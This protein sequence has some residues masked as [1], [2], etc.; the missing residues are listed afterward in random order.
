[1]RFFLIPC[2]AAAQTTS[3]QFDQMG[4][5][6]F[7]RGLYDKA[8]GYYQQA[9][10]ADPNNAQAFEDLGNAYMKK[11]D[12][13]DAVA[14]YQKSLQI[15][16]NN[17]TLKVMVDNMN[18]TPTTA[19]PDNTTNSQA[20]APSNNTVIVQEPA[21]AVVVER[22]RH[23]N[24]PQ[25]LNPDLA[26]IDQAKFWIKAELGY[27]WAQQGDLIN[28]SNTINNGQLN[29]ANATYPN[30]ATGYAG[31]ALASNSGLG[32][33]GEIG[34]LLS[35]HFGL[36]IGSRY[37]QSNDYTADVQYNNSPYNDQENLTLTPAVVP[38][39]L[40][41]YFFLPDHDGR[42]FISAGAGYY[43]GVVHVDQTTTTNNFFGTPT[44][45]TGNSTDEWT[46]DMYSGNIGFQLGIG[47]EFEVSPRFGIEIYGRAY[48]A[49]I[50]NF[51]GTL[52]DGNTSGTFAL[53]SSS[54]GPALVDADNPI[55]VNSANQERYT[56]I[57]FTGFDVGASLNFY[58]F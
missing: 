44:N 51:Q 5:S 32:W 54:S 17:P 47:R 25:N 27:D 30:S 45:G 6:L 2:L 41:L 9:I 52:Y 55:Y 35:P 19:I 15:N 12:Q 37:I 42:F 20:Q 23:R 36:A 11:G 8:I 34:F 48:Y 16:P 1:M 13:P 26:P 14:A 58:Y 3:V 4:Q 18:N 49:Q 57:D 50:T 33:G 43:L 40:D 22:V 39:T 29:Y 53:A 46:G 24:V 10:Q 7:E 56:T 21:H 38:I 28:S 31:S